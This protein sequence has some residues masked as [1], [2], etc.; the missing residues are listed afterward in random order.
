MLAGTHVPPLSGHLQDDLRCPRQLSVLKAH[1]FGTHEID[2]FVKHVAKFN[3]S[4]LHEWQGQFRI[5]VQTVES[6]S[7]SLLGMASFMQDAHW[8]G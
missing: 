6:H 5:L 3:V 1:E 8:E 2:S 7:I 4:M